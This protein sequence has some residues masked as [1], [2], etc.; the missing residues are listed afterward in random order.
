MN[1]AKKRRGS[2]RQFFVHIWHKLHNDKD[3][4]AALEESQHSNEDE[5]A[6]D[7][8]SLPSD[9]S[10]RFQWDKILADSKIVVLSDKHLV[11]DSIFAS[12]AQTTTCAVTVADRIGRCKDH[13]I[14]SSGLMCKWCGGK[15]GAYGRYFPSNL[16]TFSQVE[17]C[18]QIVKH[19]TLKCTACPYEIRNAISEM[20]DLEASQPAKR[21]PSRMVFFRRVWHRFHYGENPDGTVTA[22]TKAAAEDR[23]DSMA[24]ED[25]PWKRLVRDSTLVTMEEYGLVLDSQFAAIAQMDRCALTE[26]DQIGYNKGR[27][28]GF[29][30]MVR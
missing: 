28:I 17:V 27:P 19:M 29:L 11:P 26:A 13:K 2:R 5:K 8:A 3:S 14:G 23:V 7:S 15:P 30:G 24:P 6:D 21:Y 16:H 12:V 22:E 20:Q 4:A 25:I 1:P 10:G 9:E 18:K